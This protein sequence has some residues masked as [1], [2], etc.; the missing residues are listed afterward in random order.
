MANRKISFATVI[1]KKNEFIKREITIIWLSPFSILN[2]YWHIN[3]P[4]YNPHPLNPLLDTKDFLAAF[5]NPLSK[6]C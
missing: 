3:S 2:I 4:K 1:F 6:K 5:I